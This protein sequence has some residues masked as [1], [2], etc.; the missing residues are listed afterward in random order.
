MRD[1]QHEI[2][3]DL[4]DV[5]NKLHRTPSRDDYLEHG[6][7]SRRDIDIAFGGF[8][9]LVQ[10]C[11]L[12]PNGARDPNPGAREKNKKFTYIPAKPAPDIFSNY[13]DI[14]LTALFQKF[15][16]PE[17]LKMMAWPDVHVEHKDD[18][19]V[20]CALEIANHAKPDIFLDLGDFLNAGGLSHWPS[21]TLAERRIV[22]E[23]E[24]GRELLGIIRGIIGDKS[25]FFFI[26]G[27]HEDWIRQFIVSGVNPQ[28]FDGLERLGLEI[29]LPKLLGFDKF[30]IIH[31]PLN[32]LVKIGNAAFTHG[33]YTGDNHPKQH[34]VKAK[35]TTYYGH[36]H[37]GKAYEDTSIFGPVRAQSLFCLCDLNPTFL[38]GRLNNWSHG[39]AEFLLFPD[40]THLFTP[41][42]IVNG[43]ASY[44][45]KLFKA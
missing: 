21:D 14:G 6:K 35:F 2:R 40:G 5:A 18:Y 12:T 25:E 15:G 39:V 22:P 33:L 43:R 37:D 8:T 23:C 42:Q 32:K 10:A 1:K 7:Y 3:S 38:K 36:T 27:N 26:E 11:G 24:R 17:F 13:I 4:L 41:I 45:G 20:N 30:N 34:L 19:A 16:N 29:S 28:L 9:I 31:F 44:G